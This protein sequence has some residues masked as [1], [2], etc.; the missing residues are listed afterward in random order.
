MRFANIARWAVILGAAVTPNALNII[1]N[2]DDGFGAANIREFYR[3]LKEAG[4]N[5]LMVAPVTNNSGQ[6]GRAVFTTERNL[7]TDSQYG[8]IPQG[9]PSFGTDPNDSHIWYYNGTPAACTFFALDYVVPRYW[10]GT[11]PD[12]FV[13]GPN[14]GSNAG[15]FLFTIS[16]TMGATYAAVGRGIPGIAFS[17]S[18]STQR[19]YKT[20]DGSETAE[21]H[22][23]D[24]ATI[25]AQLSVKLVNELARS[26][27][28]GQPLL[29]PGYG[30]NVNF[31]DVS[32]APGSDC[33]YPPFYLTRLTGG[34]DT[35]Y[36]AYNETTGLF[37]YEDLVPP[38]GTGLNAC[39]N[40]DCSLPGE[41]ELLS[42][43]ATPVSLFTVD[44]DAPA[45]RK[46]ASVAHA[47]GRLVKKYDGKTVKRDTS[48]LQSRYRNQQ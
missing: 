4:H 32:S 9:A 31:P 43:C 20:V 10:N 19:S 21:G 25:N 39:I 8:L 41:T 44:Y 26:A 12:L 1:L 5:V 7:T 47:I 33:V 30:L 6:G 46:T 16:G 23:A 45:T 15:P 48:F 24:P 36:A 35:D 40:G 22:P 11:Q 42:K 18:N 17:A 29:P 38:E 3:V 28:P 13:A 34:A 27:K 2:N 37:H 14:F